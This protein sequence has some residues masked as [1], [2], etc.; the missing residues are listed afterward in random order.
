MVESQKFVDQSVLVMTC[1]ERPGGVV[2]IVDVT[3]KIF[4]ED[5]GDTVVSVATPEDVGFALELPGIPV[6][7]LLPEVRLE[8]PVEEDAVCLLLLPELLVE[9]GLEFPVETVMGIEPVP[10]MEVVWFI[11]KL[12]IMLVAELLLLDVRL[13]FSVVMGWE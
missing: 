12:G 3:S 10:D 6:T 1:V 7:G 13:G 11:L 4:K 2:V 9:L 8:D 5:V